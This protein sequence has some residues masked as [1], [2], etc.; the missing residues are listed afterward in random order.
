MYLP[1]LTATG[2]NE[3]SR[4]MTG[5]SDI[6]D[7]ILSAICSMSSPNSPPLGGGAAGSLL[8]TTGRAARGTNA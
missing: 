1:E 5:S 3:F 6:S 2:S 7:A 8:T 4:S